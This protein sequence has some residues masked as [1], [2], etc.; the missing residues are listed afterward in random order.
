MASHIVPWTVVIWENFWEEVIHVFEKEAN[1]DMVQR[2]HSMKTQ[3]EMEVD[4]DEL[5]RILKR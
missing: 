5:D 1:L 2:L 4:K 3:F